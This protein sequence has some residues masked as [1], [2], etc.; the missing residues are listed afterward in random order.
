[1]RVIDLLVSAWGRGGSAIEERKSPN[2]VALVEE[3]N[4]I[5]LDRDI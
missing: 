1:M 4:E 2:S 5:C 3:K